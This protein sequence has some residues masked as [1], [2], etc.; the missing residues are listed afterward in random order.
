MLEVGREGDPGGTASR[1]L[2][3]ES[4]LYLEGLGYEMSRHFDGRP[5]IHI[6]PP[7]IHDP[8]I[9]FCRFRSGMDDADVSHLTMPRSFFCRSWLIRVNY[10]DTD[11]S[12]SVMCWNDFDDCDFSGAD[13]SDCDMR[14]SNFT[15]CRFVGAVLRRSDLRLSTFDDCDFTGA[16]LAGAVAEGTGSRAELRD[17]LSDE[18]R[19]AVSWAEEEGPQPPGG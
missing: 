5:R 15:R 18:Q 11:L 16:E 7:S 1:K 14:A 6:G 17:I 13:L 12:E 9:G 10:S 4:W 2:L 3:E 8:E 19:L